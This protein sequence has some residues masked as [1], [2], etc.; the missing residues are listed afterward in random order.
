MKP[1][2]DPSMYKACDLHSLCIL[3]RALRSP[4][5]TPQLSGPEKSGLE[6]TS[7]PSPTATWPK[8]FSDIRGILRKL[9]LWVTFCGDKVVRLRHRVLVDS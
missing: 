7:L 9:Q 2:E 8:S 6:V 1:A 5:G 3:L 4:F